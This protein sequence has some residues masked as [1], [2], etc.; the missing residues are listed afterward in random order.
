MISRPSEAAQVVAALTNRRHGAEGVTVALYGAGGFGKTILASTVCADRRVRRRFGG[1]VYWVTVGRDLRGAEAM[2]AKVN[3]LI[4]VVSG[5]DAAFTDPQ[6]AGVRLGVL[7]DAGPRRL[8]ILDDVWEHEQL[9]PFCHGGRQCARLVTTR[10]PT[11]TQGPEVTVRVDQMSGAE[12]QALLTSGLPPLNQTVTRELLTATG[13]WPLLIGLINKILTE[14]SRSGLDVEATGRALVIRLRTSGPAAVDDLFGE[15]RSG[16]DIGQPAQRAKAVRATIEASTSLLDQRDSERF[17]ELAVF[18]EN[19]VI[20]FRHVA[21]LWRAT[22]GLDE[23]Q[24]AQLCV[25]LGDLALV[26]PTANGIRLHD[27]FRDFLRAELG[28][29]RLERL[30]ELTEELVTRNVR[31]V[32]PLDAA[33]PSPVWPTWWE[34]ERGNHGW[35]S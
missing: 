11:L 34:R 33:P 9:T 18:G 24:S 4:R 13:R 6:I 27:V 23:L 1:G 8:L 3:D 10:V 2:A 5:E 35:P 15:T 25:R 17:A 26:S 21:W 22:A 29:Q 19:E 20:P 30:T 28:S 16:L 32:K 7:L 14:A 31:A 12:A